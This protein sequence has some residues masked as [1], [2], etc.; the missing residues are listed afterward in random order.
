MRRRLQALPER[1]SKVRSA[2][3]EKDINQLGS[4]LE[5]EA[6][7]LHLVAMSSQP[8]IFYWT[9]GTIAVLRRVREV[10]CDGL[11]A[12]STI[13]AG[14]NVHV[15]CPS[16]QETQVADALGRMAE[17]ESVITD[18]V[19]NGPYLTDEHLV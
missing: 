15:I 7:E 14:P 2:I 16:D 12:F 10:R 18:R 1:L 6:L 19:G 8:P 9:G 13:D 4:V 5:E 11:Q 17:I 3:A